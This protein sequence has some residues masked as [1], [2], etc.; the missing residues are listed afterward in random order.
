MIGVMVISHGGMAKG[1]IETCDMVLGNHKCCEY[2]CLR[3]GVEHFR[4]ELIAALDRMMEEYSQIIVVT[5]LHGGT[6]YNQALDY[7][8]RKG[9]DKMQLI[10]GF[11][12][13]MLVELMTSLAYAEDAKT[14]AEHIVQTAKESIEL[15]EEREIENDDDM[16]S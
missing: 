1:A 15:Y 4:S 6:P 14:L 8:L 9:M 5:D 2:L 16:F 3:D 7:K 13:P 11:N 12:F 10:C